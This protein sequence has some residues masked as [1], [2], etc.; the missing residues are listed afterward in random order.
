MTVGGIEYKIIC[1]T[2]AAKYPRKETL[3][4]LSAE[5]FDTADGKTYF[6]DL[7][8]SLESKTVTKIFRNM[9]KFLKK[10]G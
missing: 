3:I 4:D 6:I 10:I 9:E 2:F 7:V 1:K 8:Q 5:Y